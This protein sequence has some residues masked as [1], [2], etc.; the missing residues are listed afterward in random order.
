MLQTAIE[1]AKEAGKM[2]RENV[3]NV[4]VGQFEYKLQFDYVTD[5]DRKSEQIIIEK[6]QKQYP[7]HKILAE[8]SARAES[9]EF[10]WIIDPLDGTTNFIHGYPVYSVS[11]ALEHNGE[12]ILGVVYDPSRDELFTAEQGRGAYL[13]GK[14]IKVSQNADAGLCLLATGFPFRF[15]EYT[16]L[17]LKSFQLLMQKFSGIRRAGSAALDL[18]YIACG[19]CDGFWEIGL[20]PWDIA[21]GSILI[22]EAGGRMTDF[23][24][25]NNPIWSGN[26]VA[27]N[28]YVHVEIL[29]VTSQVFY[30][31]IRDRLYEY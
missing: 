20:A 22:Q 12:I 23:F 3:G 9:A 1:A 15:K 14:R 6:I 7:G 13:N 24:E 31:N 11:I 10:R 21:A 17:Y 16:E 27:S 29:Q 5:I 2:I 19:R 30:G 18:S 28:G 26:V 4:H 8:E 25:Q